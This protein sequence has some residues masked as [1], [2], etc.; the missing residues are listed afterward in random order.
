MHNFGTRVE[1]LELC[2]YV[3]NDQARCFWDVYLCSPIFFTRLFLL[4]LI[5]ISTLI[6]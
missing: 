3:E 2:V 6:L 1:K 4:D 5:S